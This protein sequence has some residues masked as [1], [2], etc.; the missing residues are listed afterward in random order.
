[1]IKGGHLGERR[2]LM[3]NSTFQWFFPARLASGKGCPVL[4]EYGSS[5][6]AGYI[7]AMGSGGE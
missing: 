3:G 4:A 5:L 6:M 7:K 2:R 1:M